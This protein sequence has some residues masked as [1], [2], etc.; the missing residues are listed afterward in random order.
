MNDPTVARLDDKYAYL[1]NAYGLTGLAKI[2]GILEFTDALLDN[3]C[4]FIIFAH[5]YEVLDAIEEQ[6]I[7][8]KVSHIR[9]DG[10]IEVAKR[11][12]AV[13]KFQTD[14]ECLVA[15]LSLT[16]S[17]TGITLTAASTV[18]FAEMNWTPGIMV[19]AEDRAHRIGQT[20]AVNVYY[21]IGENTL[22][23]MI[24]PRLKLKSEVFSN[25]VDGCQANFS[26]ENEY[27][28][29]SLRAFQEEQDKVKG[30]SR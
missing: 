7:R 30:N 19:Q 3:K 16:A 12:E 21:L 22:D 23:A 27:D 5:H 15:V 28:Y 29:A 4:K 6:V 18:V 11:Y 20:T 10:K 14:S 2:K 17:C 24:Y 9:I 25:I 1:V 8:K 13:R 26:L